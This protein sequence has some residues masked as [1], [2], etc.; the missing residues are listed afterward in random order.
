MESLSIEQTGQICC[1][2]KVEGSTK[3][4][5]TLHD[6]SSSALNANNRDATAIV[7]LATQ[8]DE[9]QRKILD[10]FVLKFG[11]GVFIVLYIHLNIHT[12]KHNY[13]YFVSFSFSSL[14][15]FHLYPSP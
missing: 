14:F 13:N 12:N 9:E 2:K 4:R 11:A 8:L 6:L 1:D 15:S 7:L 3:R 5:R 10:K